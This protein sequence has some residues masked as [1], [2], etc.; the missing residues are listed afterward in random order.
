V[1]ITT[2]DVAIVAI[3]TGPGDAE[4]SFHF[5]TLSDFHL[6]ESIGFTD[7]GYLASGAFR[8]GIGEGE[9]RWDV[10]APTRGGTVVFLPAGSGLDLGR[11]ADQLFAFTGAIGDDGSFSDLL[12]YGLNLGGPWAADAT[13]A[14]TSSLPPSLASANVALGSVSNCAYSGATRGSKAE[15]LALIGDALSW[16][17]S[18][19]EQ[20]RPPT[21]FTV[22][23]ALGDSCTDDA[24]CVVGFCAEGVCCDTECRRREP[25]HCSACNFGP[26]DPRTGTCQAAP[27]TYLCRSSRGDCDPPEMCDGVSTECPENGRA[28]AT[29]VC[30]AST[31]ACDPEESCTGSDDACPDD[32]RTTLSSCDDDDPCTADGCDVMGGCM[33]VPVEGCGTGG[34]AGADGS[35]DA[36]DAR[37]IPPV[38]SVGGGGCAGCAAAPEGGAGGWWIVFVAFVRRLR[39]RGADR[40][41]S[42]TVSASP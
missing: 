9:T 17:C 29:T 1:L 28:S 6:G 14:A 3:Y 4:V 35:T 19:T 23:A 32:V 16:T 33:H 31:G 26:A 24:D 36:P 34:D 13:D 21:S 41:R 18:D 12:V 30:R 8:P 42:V 39:R 27:T 37:L 5:V 22:L 20:P 2:G 11:R 10:A 25:G 40:L 15:L 7:R 38:G